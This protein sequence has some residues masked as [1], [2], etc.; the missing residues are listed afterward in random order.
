MF[1]ALKHESTS[2][3]ELVQL[4]KLK[5]KT[6]LVLKD[7]CPNSPM[8]RITV[9]ELPSPETGVHK[10]HTTSTVVKT[11]FCHLP[12]S[13]ACLHILHRTTTGVKM[14]LPDFLTL[15]QDST[16]IVRSLQLW[17]LGIRTFLALK[18]TSTTYTT[19]KTT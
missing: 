18:H 19:V 11:E 12:G 16:S 1:P 4:W 9:S 6:F 5:F 7:T 8:V 2:I 10:H 14:T 13:E 15:K 17:K 3:K